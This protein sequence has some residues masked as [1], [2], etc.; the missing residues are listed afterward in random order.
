[1]GEEPKRIPL[2]ELKEV[3]EGKNFS[4]DRMGKKYKTKE[5]L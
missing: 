3:W 2:K 5:A 4:L 1:L